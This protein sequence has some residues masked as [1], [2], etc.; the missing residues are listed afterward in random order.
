LRDGNRGTCGDASDGWPC[1][2]GQI[3]ANTSLDSTTEIRIV[4]PECAF[5]PRAFPVKAHY[6]ELKAYDTNKGTIRFPRDSPTGQARKQ[7]C[8][9][10]N[11]KVLGGIAEHDLARVRTITPICLR[12]P[13][14]NC[15][16]VTTTSHG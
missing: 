11:R 10:S 6:D 14:I 12:I 13:E 5:Y 2:Q 9:V 15:S 4:G 16:C 7:A 3:G 1:R 8:N